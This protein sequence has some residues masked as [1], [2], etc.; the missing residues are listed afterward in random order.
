[1]CSCRYN[2]PR[3]FLKPKGNL[4]VLFEEEEE[5][6]P[7]GIS[8]DTVSITRVCGTVTSSY[9]PPVISWV[10]QNQ[11][12]TKQRKNH[13]RMPKVQLRCPP[14]RNISKILFASFGTPLGDCENYEKGSCHSSNSSAIVEKV[15]FI[16]FPLLFSHRFMH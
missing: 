13:G 7:L 14:R 16:F 5:G 10:G 2:V 8:I 6:N 12:R 4:L 15:S 3:S 1:M 11:I 9:P